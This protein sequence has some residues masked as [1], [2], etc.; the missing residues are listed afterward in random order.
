MVSEK[1]WKIEKL[2]TEDGQRVITIVHLSL[3]LRC[4]KKL[5]WVM[6]FESEGLLIV[7]IFLTTLVDI[8]NLTL[9]CDL[10]FKNFHISHVYTL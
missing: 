3:R 6:T 9:K 1:K 5:S 10:F 8:V 2:T 4:T 7:A